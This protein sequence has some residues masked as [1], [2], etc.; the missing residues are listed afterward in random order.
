MSHRQHDD[1][2]PASGC[3]FWVLAMALVW[4]LLVLALMTL[5]TCY[6][7]G[8]MRYALRLLPTTSTLEV[9]ATALDPNATKLYLA[10][11]DV[12]ARGGIGS[13]V[14]TDDIRKALLFE[15]QHE[16]MLAWNTQSTVRPYRPDGKPN[17][18]LTAYSMTVEP[19]NEAHGNA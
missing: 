5:H 11:F 9:I 8:K 16:A 1:L 13:E 7:G 2:E 10:S 4:A 15:T 18:P 17:R 12:D 14:L 6:Q 19:F 3:L